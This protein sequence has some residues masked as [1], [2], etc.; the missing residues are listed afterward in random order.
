MQQEIYYLYEIPGIKIGVTQDLIKRQKQHKDKGTLI[1]LGEYTDI[2]E[3]SDIEL[4]LQAEKGYPV[5]QDPYWYVVLK[6]LPLAQAP[7]AIRKRVASHDY[8]KSRPKAIANTDWKKVGETWKSNPKNYETLINSR[9]K[10]D[11]KAFGEKIRKS[12]IGKKWTDKIKQKQS[13][14]STKYRVEQYTLE[15]KYIKTWRNRK[16]AVDAGFKGD[17]GLCCR[18]KSKSAGGF[19]WKYRAK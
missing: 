18:G 9:K 14:S 1:L 7:D 17:I 6:K 3:V 8:K 19:I 11:W 12:R 10:I 16:E 15:G 13:E 5:D 2:F 4:K